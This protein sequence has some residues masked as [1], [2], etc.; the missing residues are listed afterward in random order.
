MRLAAGSFPGAGL[1]SSQ[2]NMKTKTILISL[3]V[4]GL[5]IIGWAVTRRAA[6]QS[7]KVIDPPNES[8]VE[9]TAVEKGVTYKLYHAALWRRL[10]QCRPSIRCKRNIPRPVVF[11]SSV[12][13]LEAAGKQL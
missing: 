12:F 8:E 11:S 3:A 10:P 2:I 13:R 6:G 7:S 1:F 4:M 5:L 9:L